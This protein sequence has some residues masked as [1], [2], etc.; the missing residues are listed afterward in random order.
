MQDPIFKKMFPLKFR[1]LY[2][3]IGCLPLL[4]NGCSASPIDQELMETPAEAAPEVQSAADYPSINVATIPATGSLIPPDSRWNYPLSLGFRPAEDME[5]LVNPPRFSWRY[6]KDFSVPERREA[7][8]PLKTFRFQI[9][10]DISFEDPTVDIVTKLNFYNALEPLDP[11]RWYWRVAYDGESESPS[12]WSATRNFTVTE[13]TPAWDRSLLLDAA[14]RVGQISRPRFG[15]KNGEWKALYS[16]ISKDP[17]LRRLGFTLLEQANEAIASN[18]WI[19]GLPESDHL[20]NPWDLPRRERLQ[21]NTMAKGIAMAA[22]AW[23]LTGKSDY[24]KAKELL[25]DFSKYEIGGLSS[26]EWHGNPHK[27]GTEIVKFLGLA[28]DW[29]YE[30]LSEAERK[31]IREAIAWRIEAI[32]QG[33]KSWADDGKIE[34]LGMAI[35]HGSHP[36]QN[37]MWSVPAILAIAGESAVADRTL[38][39]VL[40]Y[41]TGVSASQGPEEAYNE[42]HGYGNEKGGAYLDAMLYVHMLAPELQMGKNPQ[43]QGLGD[44]Y[45]QLF[46]LGAT[47]L[48]WGDQWSNMIALKNFQVYNAYKLAWLTGE[49][50]HTARAEALQRWRFHG[51]RTPNYQ[52]AYLPLLAFN[53]LELP[54]ADLSKEKSSQLFPVSGWLFAGSHRPSDFDTYDQ[55]IQL[56][57]QA[58]PMGR[59]THSY[60]SDGSFIWNAFGHT[61]SAGGDNLKFLNPYRS[62]TDSHNGLLINGRGQEYHYDQHYVETEQPPVMAYPL[63]WE[64]G[65][66]YLYWAVDISPTYFKLPEVERIVRHVIMVDKKFFVIYDHLETTTGDRPHLASFLFKVP[67]RVPVELANQGFRFSLDDIQAQVAFANTPETLELLNLAGREGYIN[68][69]RDFDWGPLVNEQMQRLA[70][71]SQKGNMDP[72]ANYLKDIQVWNNIWVNQPVDESGKA[73]FLSALLAWKGET[74]PTVEAISEKA[75]QIDWVDGSRYRISFDPDIPADIHVDPSR[76]LQTQ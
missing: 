9:A 37:T 21:F 8:L 2:V 53:R 1:S 56:Q 4:L 43:L 7:D 55:S 13:D 68:P 25:V 67:E 36:Y 26:P 27:F 14:A 17:L 52:E 31:L 32:F 42:G 75:L 12:E 18:W 19:K 29:L 45:A 15:P 66:N 6:E 54:A 41:L 63:A 22:F 64:E 39:M 76:V 49:P 60:G 34:P 51:S 28:Y 40:Q 70:S 20:G 16:E 11:G 5:S 57:M 62:A 71:R 33:G 50:R 23:K 24:A 59:T 65:A 46:A 61:L 35:K 10:P 69:V 72:D 47:R 48:S 74:A 73:H 58:R 30:D 38:P 44:W 3:S